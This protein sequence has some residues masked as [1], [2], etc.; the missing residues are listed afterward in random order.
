MTYEGRSRPSYTEFNPSRITFDF[1]IWKKNVTHI[2]SFQNHS[3]VICRISWNKKKQFDIL[4]SKSMIEQKKF[5]TFTNHESDTMIAFFHLIKKLFPFFKKGFLFHFC[6]FFLVYHLCLLFCKP[7][8]V[9]KLT[10]IS[11]KNSKLMRFHV[12]LIFCYNWIIL[13]HNECNF[14]FFW[15]AQKV[16]SYQ[17]MILIET[18]PCILFM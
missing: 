3:A 4:I 6:D 15:F 16:H 8:W 17:S 12:S 11:I 9:I 14:H 7:R 1:L 2:S 18:L 5:Q 10:F 13:S